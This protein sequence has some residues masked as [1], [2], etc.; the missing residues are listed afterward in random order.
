MGKMGCTRYWFPRNGLLR[1]KGNLSVSKGLGSS[2]L[3]GST[4]SIRA[5]MIHDLGEFTGLG[6]KDTN[7]NV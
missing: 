2:R 6:R 7:K 4:C 3:D 1:K 5:L